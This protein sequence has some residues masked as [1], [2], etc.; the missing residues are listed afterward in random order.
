MSRPFFTAL[1]DTYN[2]ESFI[3]DA[4]H[5]VLG[6]D[7]PASETEILVVD[8]GSTDD[9]SDLVQ[10]FQPR[11]RLLRKVN[12]GQASAFNAGLREA[13]GEIVAFLDGD[14]WWAQGKLT[15][16]ANVFEAMSSVGLVGHGITNV[17]P[18]GRQIA[19][20]PHETLQFRIGSVEGAKA[21][22]TRRGFLGTSRMA[23]RRRVLEQIG[24][25]PEKLKFEADEYLF[26]LAGLFADVLI[27]HDSYT[28]Y[29]LHDKNLYQVSIG[30]VDGI[31]KKQEVIAALA[32]SLREKLG[33]LGVPA[34]IANT[35]LECVQVEADYL[36][37]SLNGGFPWETVAT[38]LGLMRILYRDASF[39]QHLFSCTRLLPAMVMPPQAYYRWRH[40]F[41]Q[42]AFYQSFRRKYFPFPLPKHVQ[43][44]E[45]TAR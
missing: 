12:G 28:F 14:D 1:I 24:F 4:I 19:E 31:R 43:R 37:L 29:R 23:Y 38:E 27:L 10:K 16:V 22:R 13:R 15:A 17:Y 36:R 33:E 30:E 25:V 34:K 40:R 20:V 45:R 6:Q 8:D 7:F 44:E 18:D 39:W 5:S 2:Q 32:K 41:S 26:T 11:V 21:F 3:A 35:I 9:T 42:A